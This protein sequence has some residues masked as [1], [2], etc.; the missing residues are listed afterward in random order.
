MLVYTVA[1]NTHP[2][3]LG[4]GGPATAAEI[5]GTEGIWM[6]G[7]CNLYISENCRIRKVTATTGIITTIAG[8]G[9]PGYSGDGELA[10]NGEIKPYGLFSDATGN[11]Y[12]A[13]ADNNRIRRVDAITGVINT[14]AGGGGVT[15]G[16]NGPA[17]NAQLNEPENVYGDDAG[18]IY[19]GEGYGRLRKVNTAGVITTIAGTGT[20]GYSGDGGPATDAQIINPSGMLFDMDDNF[21]FA[22]RANSIIRKINSEGIITTIAGIPDSFGYSGDGGPATAAQLSGPISFVIDYLGNMVIG[23]NQ[24]NCMRKVDATT[25]IITTIA[26]VDTG[27][28]GSYADGVPATAANI[29]PEFMYLDRSGNI[30][31]SC[32]CNQVRKVIHY[33]PAEL[34]GANNCGETA[35]PVVQPANSKVEIYPNPASDKIAIMATDKIESLELLNLIGQTVY[36]QS[37]GITSTADVDISNFANGVYF[38]KSE[39]NVHR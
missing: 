38:V 24:N 22:D 33:N 14:Y 5:S 9:T 16:D 7:S 18:N 3:S 36:K 19:I 34:Y 6:D 31:Y 21:Y 29:H 23:D 2:I 27:I 25:G 15:L 11:V 13:D 4:D 20:R 17:T 35:V 39:W 30:Y 10:T 8:N 12:I 1:G 37:Y 26:G 32:Y 28:T